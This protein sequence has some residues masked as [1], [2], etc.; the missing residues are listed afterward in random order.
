MAISR[1]LFNRRNVILAIVVLVLA[2]WG[3]QMRTVGKV[4]VTAYFPVTVGVYEGSEVRLMGVVIGKVTKVEPEGERVRVELVYDGDYR[5]PADAKAVIISPSIIADR[6]VQL[7]PGYDGDGPVLVD[8]AVIGEEDT[9]VPIELDEVFSVTNDLLT[10]LGP[11]GANDEGALNRLLDVGA[12]TLRGQGDDM[13]SVIANL[14][15]AATTVGDTSGDLFSQVQHL[16]RFTASLAAND[17]EVQRFNQQM[18]DVSAF[19]SA[20]RE[21]LSQALAALAE[22]FSVVEA[23][24]TDNRDLLVV[25]IEHLT[26]IAGALA[27]ERESLIGLLEVFPSAASNMARS[28]DPEHQSIRARANQGELL[29]DIGGLLC[30]TLQSHGVPQP[31]QACDELQKLLAGAF[32]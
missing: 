9:Q 8:G 15:G 5:V 1:N 11:R 25:N 22:A 2:G 10:A 16:E 30:D 27:A 14:S 20:E 6:F 29:R 3:V 21:A 23:F 28:W 26:T 17:E 4:H 13:R 18:A 32:G 12:H 7:A 19:L 24:V 31:D